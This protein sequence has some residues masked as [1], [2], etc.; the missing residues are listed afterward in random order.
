V[1]LIEAG[2]DAVNSVAMHETF[3]DEYNTLTDEDKDELVE[4]H[5]LIKDRNKNFRRTNTKGRVEDITNTVRNIK[6]LVSSQAIVSSVS[7]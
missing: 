6:R 4:E 7:R 5:H 3:I 2:I 1:Y